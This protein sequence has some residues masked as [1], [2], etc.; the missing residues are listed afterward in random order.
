MATLRNGNVAMAQ[1]EQP[2]Q[3]E[4]DTPG[5]SGHDEVSR[6]PQVFVRSVQSAPKHVISRETAHIASVHHEPSG[7]RTPHV[8]V[9]TDNRTQKDMIVRESHVLSEH[10]EA[11]GKYSTHTNGT[12]R[13]QVPSL[14]KIVQD[15][16]PPPDEHDITHKLF[17]NIGGIPYTPGRIVL[18]DAVWSLVT[19]SCET[20]W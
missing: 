5:P 11:N 9:S 14:C 17:G 2:K 4:R 12:R 6:R 13:S 20:V 16:P 18:F 19:A 3:I 1:I 10:H 8:S 15:A 7:N